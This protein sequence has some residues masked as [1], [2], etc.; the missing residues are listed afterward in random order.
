MKGM[1]EIRAVESWPQAGRNGGPDY[2]CF[3]D[4]NGDLFHF[5]RAKLRRGKPLPPYRSAD[6]L[7]RNHDV[8]TLAN[9]SHI[10]GL[11]P[12]ILK[13]HIYDGELEAIK[14]KWRY[15]NVR[16]TGWLLRLKDL[17]EVMM[18]RAIRKRLGEL[19]WDISAEQLL[20]GREQVGEK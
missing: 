11:S 12:R 5:A 10:S 14:K 13:Q 20:A 6:E 17:R 7:T 8:L 18:R 2:V 1:G 9:A 4:E 16:R 3:R 15:G 19:E